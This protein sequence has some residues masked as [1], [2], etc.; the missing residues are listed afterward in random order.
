M[1]VRLGRVGAAVL[2]TLVVAC[3]STP[4]GPV[5]GRNSPTP[6]ARWTPAPFASPSTPTSAKAS[7]SRTPAA[8]TPV[9]IPESLGLTCSLP[10]AL[11]GETL[12][13]RQNPE[14]G[15]L[16]DF[17]TGRLIVVPE[18]AMRWDTSLNPN[19]VDS[20]A[21]PLL[22]GDGGVTFDRAAGRWL[23]ASRT[24]VSPDGSR[25]TYGVP[26]SDPA[27]PTTPSRIHV[28]DVAT[29]SDRVVYTSQGPDYPVAFTAD[30][31]YLYRSRWEIP[32]VGLALL[33]PATSQVRTITDQGYWGSFDV[34]D[35][36]GSL[37][38]GGMGS[39]TLTVDRLDLKTGQSAQWL[40]VAD[41]DSVWVMGLDLAGRPIVQ[42]G[43]IDGS[44]PNRYA[45]LA[46]P[47]VTEP[48]FS[49]TSI[50]YSVVS[51]QQG[52]WFGS[53]DGMYLYRSGSLHFAFANTP[54]NEIEYAAGGC[55]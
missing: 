37:N 24:L 47:G 48:L 4:A 5:A 49:S 29:G 26:A 21:T 55:Q 2:I 3:G 39:P 12:A 34:G 30:G 46:S 53:A 22:R 45:V 18:G 50:G 6:L 42:I 44:Y 8:A 41:P 27:G 54:G 51:D 7:S 25:F 1:S 35:A 13:D 20:V 31:I 9:P 23:P 38:V 14:R 10:V 52:L 15:A 16:V 28:V 17:K 19:L 43:P 32:P 40:R 11:R 33:D 36:W